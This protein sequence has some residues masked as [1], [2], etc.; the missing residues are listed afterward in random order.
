M[1]PAAVSLA[2]VVTEKST[3]LAEENKFVFKVAPG[4]NKFEIRHAVESLFNV[5]VSKVNVITQKGHKRSFG[6]HSGRTADWKKA[7]VT[8]RKG[9]RI[10]L[11]GV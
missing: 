1:D 4:A 5:K 8:V 9:D 3:Y 11:F 10:D 7:I 6:R 2:P